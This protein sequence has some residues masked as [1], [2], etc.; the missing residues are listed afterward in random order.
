MIRR[1]ETAL[2]MD[3]GRKRGIDQNGNYSCDEP[4]G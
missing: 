3:G 4:A 2:E 1:M